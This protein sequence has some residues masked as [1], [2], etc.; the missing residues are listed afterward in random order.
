MRRVPS[1]RSRGPR[2]STTTPTARVAAVL[3]EDRLPR[4][5]RTRNRHHLPR[6]CVHHPTVTDRQPAPLDVGRWHHAYSPSVRA[7][8]HDPLL[9]LGLLPIRLAFE[10]APPEAY[11]VAFQKLMRGMIDRW[12]VPTNI[13]DVILVKLFDVAVMTASDGFEGMM[14]RSLAGALLPACDENG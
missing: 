11:G 4:L 13:V 2:R 6:H 5:H 1:R 14:S 9:A 10:G 12:R 7:T 8:C 3:I